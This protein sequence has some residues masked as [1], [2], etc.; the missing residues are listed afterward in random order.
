MPSARA[1]L[2]RALPLGV[3]RQK[4]DVVGVFGVLFCLV[5]VLRALHVV[6]DPDV[7]W[8]AA[9]GRDAFARGVIPETNGYSYVDGAHPWVMHEGLYARLFDAGLHGLGPS[10][11]GLFALGSG[12]FLTVLTLWLVFARARSLPGAALA[13][14]LALTALPAFLQPRPSY[15]ALVFVLM[16]MG[17]S[18]GEGWTLGRATFALLVELAWTNAHGSFPFGIVLLLTA[19][20]DERSKREARLWIATSFAAVIVTFLNPYGWHLHALVD[21]YLRG[22]DETARLIHAY[23]EEFSPMWRALGSPF[24]NGLNIASLVALLALACSALARRRSV[25]R[26]LLVILLVG[27]AVYQVRHVILATVVGSIL[28]QPEIEACLSRAEGFPPVGRLWPILLTPLVGLLIGGSVWAGVRAR[29][30]PD[31]WVADDLG[32]ASLVRLTR[33]LPD[34]AR[35]YVPFQ[36][37]AVVLWEAGDRGVQ[38]L[39][40][41]RNDCYSADVAR[42]AYE[43]EQ[44]RVSETRVLQA[45]A[46]YRPDFILVPRS[47]PTYRAIVGDNTRAVRARDG[48]WTLFQ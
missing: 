19:A 40:D 30:E 2:V 4:R 25:A 11:I 28:L 22:G 14:L 45:L 44:A 36:P 21:R 6:D 41:P 18:F 16:M 33:L 43:L 13:G 39:F 24:L 20:I 47:H 34:G 7:F 27:L 3:L 32:G 35:V 23:V 29:R 8:I 38:V 10:F 15:A 42:A 17:A 12:A 37:A 48:E 26:G 46:R 31:A 1:L 9:I 5:A